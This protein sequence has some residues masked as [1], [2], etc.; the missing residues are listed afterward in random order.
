MGGGGRRGRR[1]WGGGGK[2]CLGLVS[3]NGTY[4]PLLGIN[5]ICFGGVKKMKSF[6]PTRF[7]VTWIILKFLL[8]SF[9]CIKGARVSSSG[10]EF[11]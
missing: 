5:V 10:S 2:D 3:I 1:G 7:I 8:N 9:L 11:Q 4:I 6:S